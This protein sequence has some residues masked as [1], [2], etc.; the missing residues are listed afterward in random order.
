MKV[1][2]EIRWHGRGRRRIGES[3]HRG[4][5]RLNKQDDHFDVTTQHDEGEA[6]LV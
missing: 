3:G 2:V 5:C 4:M 1:L 6:P